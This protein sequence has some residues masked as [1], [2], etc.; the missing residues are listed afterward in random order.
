MTGT[1]NASYVCACACVH[2]CLPVCLRV[3]A[4]SGCV[5]TYVCARVCVCV[6]YM[7]AC[8]CV[9]KYVCV[10]LCVCG[11][12][13]SVEGKHSP[14]PMTCDFGTLS[15][16][17][18]LIL[19]LL[20]PPWSFSFLSPRDPHLSPVQRGGESQGPSPTGRWRLLWKRGSQLGLS[21]P[22]GGGLNLCPGASRRRL[23]E[24]QPGE[25]QRPH[26]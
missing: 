11:K 8:V 18:V 16:G 9:H 2:A 26:I 22:G 12:Y 20:L 13:Y 15:S 3:C 7:C 5:R 17:P 19:Q 23:G 21:A 10:C 24:G 1:Q 4:V 14:V 6:H 25:V